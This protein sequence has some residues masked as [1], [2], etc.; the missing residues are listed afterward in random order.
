MSASLKGSPDVTALLAATVV[1]SRLPSVG[2]SILSLMLRDINLDA[3]E[4]IPSSGRNPIVLLDIFSNVLL[5]SINMPTAP[6]LSIP[7]VTQVIGSKQTTS[8]TGCGVRFAFS[9]ATIKAP[10]ITCSLRMPRCSM[11]Q[12]RWLV[13][14]D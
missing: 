5:A 2:P 7:S 1:E 6:D 8:T 10:G 12:M 11:S 3:G 13:A 9:L 4:L 14:S